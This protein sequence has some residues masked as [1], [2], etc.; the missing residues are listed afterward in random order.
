[1]RYFYCLLALL[2]PLVAADLL[3]DYVVI[4]SG[5]G[6]MV[7]AN[8]L[9]ANPNIK[10][11]LIERG[12]NQ[13]AACD[14]SIGAQS[15]PSQ[16]NQ[17][18]LFPQPQPFLS[19]IRAPA[20]TQFT[21]K[22]GNSK[23]YGCVA[24]RP[25]RELLDTYYPAGWR[26]ND[27]LPYFLKNENH[28]CYYLPESYTGISP[29]ECETYHGKGGQMDVSPQAYDELSVQV[30]DLAAYFNSTGNFNGDYNNPDKRPGAHFEQAYRR[31]A[32]RADPYSARSRMDSQIGWMNATISARPNIDIWTDTRVEKLLFSPFGEKRVLGVKWAKNGTDSIGIVIPRKRV[33]VCAGV[34]H[35]PQLLHVSGV[36]PPGWLGEAGINVVAI[37]EDV[38]IN[39]QSHAA[40]IMG[41]RTKEVV[42]HNASMSSYNAMQFFFNT[43]LEA[44]LPTDVQVELLEGFYVEGVDGPANGLPLEITDGFLS[45]QSEFPFMGPEIELHNTL[46]R[47][48]AKA[49]TPNMNDPPTWD[50][51]W[52]FAPFFGG[53]LTR[54]MIAIGT[55]R[56]WFLGNNSFA[57]EHIAE[58]IYP[59]DQFYNQLI[60]AGYDDALALAK[61]GMPSVRVLADF[62]FIQYRLT[63][64]FHLAG[65]V[66]LGTATNNKG[67]LRG[68]K[69]VMICDS[70]VLP[71]NPDGNPST[72]IM[73]LC[74][75]MADAAILED[76]PAWP[77]YP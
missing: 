30:R 48:Y 67:E 14:L 8:R 76:F 34:L 52:G 4:G 33:W 2:V 31:S 64:F 74:R 1:M 37:N 27:L 29:T 55:V 5:V 24:T 16:T 10:V 59:G 63:H 60:D 71:H 77:L 54:L 40:L 44:T 38:G 45:L 57:N 9:S 32:D 65:T 58:E 53:D 73:A 66:S 12:P 62:F 28:Y 36:G 51:G 68:V 19:L 13:C 20:H 75:K 26:Y 72:T 15:N 7:V 61:F 6:G 35:T 21:G 46:S 39:L 25:S 11:L 56:S 41:F 23:I 50:L 70:S 17:L 69:G 42:H 43:G 49:A 3:Y 47:G 22:G 18:N